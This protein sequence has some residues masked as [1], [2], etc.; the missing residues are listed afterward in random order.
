[1]FKWIQIFYNIINITV[2]IAFKRRICMKWHVFGIAKEP[3]KWSR[4]RISF[5]WHLLLQHCF[6]LSEVVIP[7]LVVNRLHLWFIYI[8]SVCFWEPRERYFWFWMEKQARISWHM[9][10][11]TPLCIFSTHSMAKSYIFL[12]C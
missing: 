7:H 4:R 9:F 8:E 2:L 3:R 12:C 6:T 11:L 5:Q 10:R 1:M